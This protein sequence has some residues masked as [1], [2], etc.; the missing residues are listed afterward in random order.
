MGV[1]WEGGNAWKRKEAFGQYWFLYL[2][3]VGLVLGPEQRVWPTERPP[4]DRETK[5]GKGVDRADQAAGTGGSCI[6][7]PETLATLSC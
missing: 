7:E 6:L 5:A 1:G 4:R 2:P 3:P